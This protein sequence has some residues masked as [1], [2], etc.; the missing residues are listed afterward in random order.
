MDAPEQRYRITY[1]H[2][3]GHLRGRRFFLV[4]SHPVNGDKS[5]AVRQFP[6]EPKGSRRHWS[7][8][9]RPAWVTTRRISMHPRPITGATGAIDGTCLH[10]RSH[11]LSSSLFPGSRDRTARQSLDLKIRRA[12]GTWIQPSLHAAVCTEPAPGAHRRCRDSHSIC[13][14]NVNVLPGMGSAGGAGLPRPPDHPAE[15]HTSAQRTG[16]GKS[17][18]AEDLRS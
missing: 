8:R 11:E 6:H 14:A 9:G 4:S 16:T 5:P 17:A 18:N 13:R 12:I 3:F 15:H 1:S 2:T 7:A 10:R